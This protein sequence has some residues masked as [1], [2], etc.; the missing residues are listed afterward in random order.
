MRVGGVVQVIE[1]GIMIEIEK[2]SG[3]GTEIVKGQESGMVGVVEMIGGLRME[4]M[5]A[6]TGTVI[7][8]GH[9]PLLGMVAGGHLEVQFAQIR[10][11]CS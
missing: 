5:V 7:G 2:G 9:V 3:T 8:A 11:L 1:I 10:G 6:G 4:G